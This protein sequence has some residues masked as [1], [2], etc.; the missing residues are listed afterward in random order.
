[1]H[2]PRNEK[3]AGRLQAQFLMK[4]YNFCIKGRFR[5]SP[6]PEYYCV[7]SLNP[8]SQSVMSKEILSRVNTMKGFPVTFTARF[9]P[10]LSK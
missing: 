7:T 2:I 10:E 6:V 9:P 8:N 4:T 3:I 1:M 5:E